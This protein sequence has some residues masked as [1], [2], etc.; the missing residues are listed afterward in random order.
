[1]VSPPCRHGTAEDLEH[2]ED[3]E[4]GGVPEL[5]FGFRDVGPFA[6][7]EGEDGDDLE[8]WVNG[9]GWGGSFFSSSRCRRGSHLGSRRQM[10]IGLSKL[11]R[12]GA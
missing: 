9:W 7:G 6:Q 10:S 3:D 5:D 4:E 12:S 11:L 8:G 2:A 1:M